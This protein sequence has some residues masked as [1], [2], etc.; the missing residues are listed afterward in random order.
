MANFQDQLIKANR[1]D[2]NTVS[3]ELFDFIRSI[4]K[5]LVE[6]NKRQINQDS[7]DIY[8]KAIGFYSRATEFL[9]LGQK[10]AGQPFTGEDTGEWLSRFYVTVLD[11]TFFFGSSDPKTD[12]ILDSPNWLSSDL[13]GLTDENLQMVIDTNF[14][15]FILNYYR[16]SLDL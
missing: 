9:T 16:T 1:I 6:L 14:L 10:K 8:G 5:E 3:K 15:P 12:D 2:A 11:N 13:F 4:S 7:Q